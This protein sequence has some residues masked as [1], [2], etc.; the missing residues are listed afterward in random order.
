MSSSSGACPS[1]TTGPGTDH[2]FLL[3]WDILPAAATAAQQNVVSYL[4][5]GP[6]SPTPL[7][8]VFTA[9][10]IVNTVCP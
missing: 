7:C 4:L 1:T 2:G 3:H 5:G 10:G 9:P 8:P 6:V